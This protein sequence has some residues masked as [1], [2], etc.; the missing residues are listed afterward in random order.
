MGPPFSLRGSGVE[1]GRGGLEVREGR[2]FDLPVIALTPGSARLHETVEL[3]LHALLHASQRHRVRVG[4]ATPRQERPVES[5]QAIEPDAGL[6]VTPR[7][8]HDAQFTAFEKVDFFS[9]RRLRL[10]S[11]W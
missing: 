3:G 4:H 5:R 2:A 6:E 8:G 7:D 1:Q 9:K 11:G 10:I